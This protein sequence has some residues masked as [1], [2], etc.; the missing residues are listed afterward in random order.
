MRLA[1]SLTARFSSPRRKKFMT[2]KIDRAPRALLAVLALTLTAGAVVAQQQ[3][4]NYYFTADKLPWH[5]ES[6]TMPVELAPLWGARAKG[7]AGTLLRVPGGFES[8]LH[9]HT[10]DYWA[11]VVQ[12]TWKHWVPSTGEGVGLK[13][14]VGAHWTQIHT[15]LHQDACV[16]KVPCVIFL[17]NKN[18]YETEF[19]KAGK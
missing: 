5:K 19:P 1:P 9:S 12:G 3:V 11:V 6:P 8:G 4:E 7:E 16:S 10:A 13:L 17:F 14:D 18:P 2:F 15:Q